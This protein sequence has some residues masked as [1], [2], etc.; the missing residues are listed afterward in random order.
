MT[1][2]DQREIDAHNLF[3]QQY[4][5]GAIK[6]SITPKSSR[7]LERQIDEMTRF[8]SIAP[9]DRVLEI[10]CGMGRCTLPLVNRGL[11]VEGLDLSPA[12]LERLRTFNRGR[13]EIPLH[14]ADILH[15]PAALTGAFDVLLGVFVLHH[16]KNLDDSFAAMRR[17]LKPHGR[18]VFLEANAYN[19]LFYLQIALTK[20]MTWEGDKGIAQ[21]RPGRIFRAMSGAG[22]QRLEIRRFGFLPSSLADRAWGPSIDALLERVP[23]WRPI[24]PFQLFKAE[25]GQDGHAPAP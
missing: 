4:F 9:G 8:A 10:G 19:P 20:G 13:G 16:L 12:L 18:M 14:C 22:L 7:H 5:E 3:Q 23:L 6:R 15:A 24:L 17:L 2:H 11:R 25:R 1:S 21:M